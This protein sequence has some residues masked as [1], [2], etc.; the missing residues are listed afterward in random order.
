MFDKDRAFKVV[1]SN[2]SLINTLFGSQDVVSILRQFS[3][4]KLLYKL[5]DLKDH[6]II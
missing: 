6:E 4:P 1:G 5:L 3:S 2:L